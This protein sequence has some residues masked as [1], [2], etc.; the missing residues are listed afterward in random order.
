MI[1][2]G[3]VIAAIMA[4]FTAAGILLMRAENRRD[5]FAS[6]DDGNMEHIADL[7][8]MPPEIAHDEDWWQET[9]ELRFT[10]HAAAV[11]R[12]YGNEDLGPGAG[13]STAGYNSHLPAGVPVKVD[14]PAPADPALTHT[15]TLEPGESFCEECWSTCTGGDPC[16]CCENAPTD[17]AAAVE[18]I[19]PDPTQ[20]PPPPVN[21]AHQAAIAVGAAIAATAARI[22]EKDRARAEALAAEAAAT[23]PWE[24]CGP[25]TNWLSADTITRGMAAIRLTGEGTNEDGDIDAPLSILAEVLHEM[26]AGV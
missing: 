11:A 5:P 13:V 18:Q 22:A 16:S 26:E 10:D 19:S 15:R 21:H 3:L 7:G 23:S 6:F 14:S 2:A 25:F 8:P 9:T 20:L 1:L 24:E 17:P 12:R 4:G